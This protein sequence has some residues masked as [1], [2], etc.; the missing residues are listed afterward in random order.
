MSLAPNEQRTLTEI[1]NR[2]RRSDPRLA[3]MFGLLTTGG[4]RC[5]MQPSPADGPR[6]HG[7]AR[8]IILGAVGVALVIACVLMAVISAHTGT[9]PIG[10]HGGGVASTGVYP[11]QG[12]RS[13]RLASS[14]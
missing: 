8:M 5:V 10:G 11:G 3:A 12:L 4:V 14:R 7:R 1:E 2:L 6:S 13:E 9:P